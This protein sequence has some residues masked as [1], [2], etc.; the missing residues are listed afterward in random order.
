[1][2]NVITMMNNSSSNAIAIIGFILLSAHGGFCALDQPDILISMARERKRVLYVDA[3]PFRSSFLFIFY[4]LFFKY[5]KFALESSQHFI[6]S[7]S[8]LRLASF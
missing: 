7:L 1:M 2:Y 3:F 4:L 8:G 5:N 6:L